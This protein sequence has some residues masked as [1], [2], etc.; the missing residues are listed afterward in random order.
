VCAS[1]CSDEIDTCI[2]DHRQE[3]RRPCREHLVEEEAFHC[4]IAV[5]M[6]CGNSSGTN[7][8]RRECIQQH[9]PELKKICPEVFRPGARWD[10]FDERDNAACG[11]EFAEYCAAKC[12]GARKSQYCEDCLEKLEHKSTKCLIALKEHEDFVCGI[13]V[14]YECGRSRRLGP[15]EFVHCIAE[16]RPCHGGI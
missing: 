3:L 8:S 6:L 5:E 15:Y 10:R 16:K 7:S 12:K 9:V 1:V 14:E 2:K 13:D 11:V 4:G